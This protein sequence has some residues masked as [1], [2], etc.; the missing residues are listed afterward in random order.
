MFLTI[1]NMKEG[2]MKLIF[3][4]FKNN[5]HIPFENT[6]YD[7]NKAPTIE[8]SELPEGTKSLMFIMHDPDAPIPGGFIHY[9]AYD[10]KPDELSFTTGKQLS[11]GTGNKGY[12]G[13][14]PPKGHGVHNYHFIVYALPFENLEAELHKNGMF[15][16]NSFAMFFSGMN[17]IGKTE[18]IGKYEAK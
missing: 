3:K 8:I 2:D 1:I 14:Q 12:F 6:A 9:L 11:N 10:I 4:E 13:P 7:A 16:T 5:S 15:L 18:I 17:A